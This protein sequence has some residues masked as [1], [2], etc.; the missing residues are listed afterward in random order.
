MT[1]AAARLTA[2]GLVRSH[3]SW[4]ASTRIPDA[5]ITPGIPAE[6]SRGAVCPQ[7]D[8]EEAMPQPRDEKHKPS[9]SKWMGPAGDP[10]EGKRNARPSR[11]REEEAGSKF[12]GP[13]GDPTEGKRSAAPKGAAG[14]A[15][16]PVA[17]EAGSQGAASGKSALSRKS[18]P[19]RKSAAYG[20]S[21]A[22]RGDSRGHAV[23]DGPEAR[24]LGRAEAADVRARNA[25]SGRARGRLAEEIGTK[26]E[27]K[28]A[29]EGDGVTRVRKSDERERRPGADKAVRKRER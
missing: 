3:A 21:L 14:N 27:I 19:P 16:A 26:A 18:I 20:K 10:A 5:R 24:G 12:M 4:A 7:C 11:R 8:M 13:A 29:T 6:P 1:P 2:H 9:G 25:E 22:Q 17:R 23:S 28:R 15:Q